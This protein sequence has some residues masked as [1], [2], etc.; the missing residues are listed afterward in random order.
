MPSQVDMDGF[1]EQSSKS[2]GR[3]MW[4]IIE[5][6]IMCN[7]VICK[8]WSPLRIFFSE[9]ANNNKRKNKYLDWVAHEMLLFSFNLYQINWQIAIANR[10]QYGEKLL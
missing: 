3:N 9:E 6:A 8:F 5:L 1:K 10:D 4:I 2:G 7:S